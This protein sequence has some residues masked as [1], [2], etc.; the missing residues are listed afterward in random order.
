MT[1]ISLKLV[2]LFLFV[3]TGCNALRLRGSSI[4]DDDGSLIEIRGM[5]YFGF[6]NGQTMLDG[7]WSNNPL[8]GDFATVRCRAIAVGSIDRSRLGVFETFTPTICAHAPLVS[9]LTSSPSPR[10]RRLFAARSCWASTRCASR[11][12]SRTSS[13]PYARSST[14][15]ARCRA[16]RRLPPR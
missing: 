14:R 9:D 2:C 12:R 3:L 1:E 5:N 13:W 11:S 4:V 16:T 6:N 10:L 8:S 15:D 7:L